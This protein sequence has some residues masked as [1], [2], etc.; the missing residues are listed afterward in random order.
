MLD[1][2]PAQPSK[3]A[4]WTS[5]SECSSLHIQEDHAARHSI[6]DAQAMQSAQGVKLLDAARM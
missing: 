1:L 4:L 3:V 5:C 2:I 6:A